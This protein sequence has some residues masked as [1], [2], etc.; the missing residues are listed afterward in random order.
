VYFPPFCY[1][2][3]GGE[4]DREREKKTKEGRKEETKNE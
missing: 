2:Q 1:I 3:Q 4:K